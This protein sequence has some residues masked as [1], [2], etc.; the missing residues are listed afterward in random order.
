MVEAKF[1]K[2]ISRDVC[3]RK[4]V[5]FERPTAS[6]GHEIV[7][8][9][10]GPRGGLVRLGY[11]GGRNVLKGLEQPLPSKADGWT[12]VPVSEAVV[13]GLYCK[14]EVDVAKLRRRG[15]ED[16][17]S[18][19]RRLKSRIQLSLG[20]LEKLLGSD[21][22]ASSVDA[23]LLH[24]N[25]WD[26]IQDSNPRGT[27]VPAETFLQQAR[28]TL[29]S[30]PSG[31]EGRSLKHGVIIDAPDYGGNEPYMLHV[32]N[33]NS[34]WWLPLRDGTGALPTAADPS[35]DIPFERIPRTWKTGFRGPLVLW[36]DAI[37]G[38]PRTLYWL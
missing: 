19:L 6:G 1:A 25:F 29:R 7:T 14:P 21:G 28:V 15:A 38:L 34:R 37:A 11:S 17:A 36:R 18:A 4:F 33:P 27:A 31:A 35:E 30:K 16:A 10:I 9:V 22:G 32:L 2:P 24:R 13:R 20:K 12:A 5:R 3:V 8:G 26:V 23:L